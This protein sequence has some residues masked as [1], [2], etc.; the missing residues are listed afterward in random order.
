MPDNNSGYIVGPAVNE[1]LAIPQAAYIPAD[2][3]PES[4]DYED[5]AKLLLC[6]VI[7]RI[8]TNKHKYNVCMIPRRSKAFNKEDMF[9]LVGTVLEGY[10]DCN[11]GLPPYCT[12]KDFHGCHLLITLCFHGLLSPDQRHNIPF[13]KEVNYV[14]IL[15]IPHFPFSA[16]YYRDI[17]CFQHGDAMH[18]KK[19]VGLH[20]R[21]GVR[22]ATVFGFHAA[23]ACA[24]V[25]GWL[26]RDA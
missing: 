2:P 21:S 16:M 4:F 13:F 20:E 25:G 26:L 17:V 18:M 11:N 1:D 5:L 3:W 7:T 12:A 6:F 23:P 22:A 9:H 19:N 10:T 15:C 24:V 8:D 14:K